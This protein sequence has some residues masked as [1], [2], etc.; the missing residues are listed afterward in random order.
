MNI[1]EILLRASQLSAKQFDDAPRELNTT[2]DLAMN[3][4]QQGNKGD[5]LNLMKKAHDLVERENLE[6]WKA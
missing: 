6:D 4:L 2:V 3:A 5:A 1:D